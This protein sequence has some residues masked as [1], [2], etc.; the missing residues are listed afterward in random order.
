MS[1]SLFRN[2]ARRSPEERYSS[3][4]NRVN[5]PRAWQSVPRVPARRERHAAIQIA[6]SPGEPGGIAATVIA[7]VLAVRAAVDGFRP[8]VRGRRKL[9][10][11]SPLD[12]DLRKQQPLQVHPVDGRQ[13]ERRFLDLVRR[14]ADSLKHHRRVRQ[15]NVVSQIVKEEPYGQPRALPSSRAL[16]F[17]KVRVGVGQHNRDSR[18][19]VYALVGRRLNV[20]GAVL[21]NSRL[22]GRAVHRHLVR[23]P[24]FRLAVGEHA[25]EDQKRRIRDRLFLQLRDGLHK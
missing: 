25:V 19:S 5:I 8:L 18:A 15:R 20:E 14:V 17:R 13:A 2:R 23:A 22:V 1:T 4:P 16:D 21:K 3:P 10:R 6:R 9:P 12:A 24:L 7:R 11:A